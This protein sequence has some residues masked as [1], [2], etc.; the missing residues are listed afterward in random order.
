MWNQNVM[1]Y[2]EGYFLLTN[3]FSITCC[4]LFK[5]T[6]LCYLSPLNSATHKKDYVA[7]SKGAKQ[8]IKH[9]WMYA[10]FFFIDSLVHHYPCSFAITPSVLHLFLQ[11]S[12]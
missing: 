4:I 12:Q 8:L 1:D 11:F 9:S 7:S 2:G 6:E 5:N 3:C 10:A